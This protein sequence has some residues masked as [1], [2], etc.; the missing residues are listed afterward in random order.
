MTLLRRSLNFHK[1][2]D[3]AFSKHHSSISLPHQFI[4][5][6]D[7]NSRSTKD[8][9]HTT[10]RCYEWSNSLLG[11]PMFPL[12]R[13]PNSKPKRNVSRSVFSWWETSNTR[14]TSEKSEEILKKAEAPRCSKNESTM[15]FP[16]SSKEIRGEG[17]WKRYVS[18]KSSSHKITRSGGR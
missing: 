8:G 13:L 1:W 15:T 14:T 18:R 11:E 7:H 9:V 6:K 17:Y 5:S 2:L 10:V 16:S 3:G 4:F 12:Q